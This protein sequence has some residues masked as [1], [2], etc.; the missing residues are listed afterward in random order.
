MS[1]PRPAA[2]RARPALALSRAAALGA[3]AAATIPSLAFAQFAPPQPLYT[4]TSA[5]AAQLD[6]GSNFLQ[7]MGR[8]A[9][10]GYA[11]RDNSAGGGASADF[12][13]PVYR[14]WFEGYGTSA[15]TGVFFS[16]FSDK[17]FT[18][19]GVAG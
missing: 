3:C 17:R 12:A 19:G 2:K 6:L 7:R 14:S 13:A 8:A 9:A 4:A 16:F 1:S 10:P 5:G 15:R 18:G 11:A